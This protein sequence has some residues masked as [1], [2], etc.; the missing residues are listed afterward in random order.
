MHRNTVLKYRNISQ[1]FMLYRD[2]PSHFL[3]SLTD[4]LARVRLVEDP[5][6][7]PKVDPAR[8]SERIY[9]IMNYCLSECPEDRPSM[10]E[11]LN[12]IKKEDR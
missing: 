4:I 12:S 1:T 7:R 3:T 2:T 8:C 11:V 6:F 9:Q 10:S 5:P